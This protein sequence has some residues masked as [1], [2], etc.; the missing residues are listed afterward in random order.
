VEKTL[1]N[2]IRLNRVALKLSIR[3]LGRRADVS[4]AQ[5]SRI[6]S[7]E[8]QRPAVKTLVAL[9]RALDGNPIPLMIMAGQVGDEEAR[10]RLDHFL[11]AESEFEQA[12]DGAPDLR[13]KVGS[14]KTTRRE[15]NEVAFDMFMVGDTE[16]TLWHDAYL[17][18]EVTGEETKDLRE[19]ISLWPTI[20]R[21]RRARVVECARDQAKLSRIEFLRALDDEEE[22]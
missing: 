12:F 10:E 22:R 16:E 5:I 9:A 14:P 7:G 17:A 8:V 20:D 18:V 21:G 11:A 13:R 19:L 2:A 1:A 3:E 4:A 15:L 6:E